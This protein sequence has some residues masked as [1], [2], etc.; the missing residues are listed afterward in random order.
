M[1]MQ[2]AFQIVAFAVGIGAAGVILATRTESGPRSFLA[3][4]ISAWSIMAA[5]F[6]GLLA[7]YVL[8]AKSL[9]R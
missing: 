6:I 1:Q 2:T 4:L 3:D 8:W 9:A 5:A 7:L